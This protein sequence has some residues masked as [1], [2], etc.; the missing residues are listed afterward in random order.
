[1]DIE[2]TG[3]K[4]FEQLPVRPVQ[5]AGRTNTGRGHQEGIEKTG[6]KPTYKRPVNKAERIRRKKKRKRIAWWRCIK[7]IMSRLLLLAAML[8]VAIFAVSKILGLIVGIFIP[9]VGAGSSF[10]E[11][12][13]KDDIKILRYDVE[14]PQV[15]EENEIRGRLASLVGKYP[16]FSEVY[17]HMDEYPEKL[18][19]S[20]CNNPEMIDF[21]K[22]YPGNTGM[23]A[24]E[25]TDKELRAKIPHLLQWDKRWGYAAY[26]ENNMVALAGCAPT[27]MSMVIVGL[28]GNEAATPDAIADY[29]M[30][31]GFYV[32]GTGTAWSLMTEGGQQWGVY[33]RE[34]SLMENNIVS[35]L[36][37]GHPIIC[38]VHAGDFTV[39]G[40]FIVLVGVENGKIRLNDPN[41][42]SRSNK[43]WD[44]SAL[45]G[46]ISNLWVFHK[47]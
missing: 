4:T 5:V 18:L 37:A 46:Q 39:E 13:L 19:A 15:I 2:L 3:V 8:T 38:S 10:A 16:E 30:Q 1:M 32:E 21:V 6:R 47:Y 20:L 35:E 29:A 24:G 43:L 12:L 11:K 36:E 33:G 23:A 34:I 31:N 42:I 25:L 14:T 28:T 41:S 26:G 45:E 7:R 40:H 9:K 17:E 22:G 27:C 44:Y